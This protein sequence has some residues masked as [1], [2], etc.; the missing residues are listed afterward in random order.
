MKCSWH[1]VFHQSF[2]CINPFGFPM[3]KSFDAASL[4]EEPGCDKPFFS[5]CFPTADVVISLGSGWKLRKQ[6]SDT[7]A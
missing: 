3:R 7:E 5:F 4:L 1:I 2:E 6:T